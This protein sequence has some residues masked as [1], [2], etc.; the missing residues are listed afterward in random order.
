MGGNEGE[1]EE[2]EGKCGHTLT[3]F[4][5]FLRKYDSNKGKVLHPFLNLFFLSSFF[6]S[7]CF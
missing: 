5:L 2:E 3:A 7:F 6:K 1:D 4:L